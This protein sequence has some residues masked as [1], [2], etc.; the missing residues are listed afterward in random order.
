MRLTLPPSL[1]T[2]WLIP[3]L[4][5]FER[6]QPDIELQLVPTTRVV[7]LKRDQVDLAVRH[8]KGSWPGIDATFL[9]GETALP[10]CAPGYFAIRPGDDPLAALR[11]VRLVVNARSPNE[12]EEWARARG[13][14]PPPLG[15]AIALEGLEQALQ[16]AESGH[17]LAIGRRPMV[18]D[19]LAKGTLVAPF[20]AG[21]PTGAAY[22]RCRPAG[23]APTAQARRLERWL[24]ALAAAT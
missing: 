13:L 4:G 19:R 20:G 24:V 2:T 18:D 3:Q 15:A 7:D 12:W 1:A 14:E 9:L 11:S 5:A 17:G 16:V 6:E 22:L 8:G 23:E 10:V 21:D